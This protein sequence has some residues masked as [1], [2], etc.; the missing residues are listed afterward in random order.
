MNMKA[1]G[2]AKA[3]LER[4]GKTAH[5]I[6]MDEISPQKLLGMKLD[7]LVNCACPRLTDDSGMFRKPVLNPQDVERL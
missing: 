4:K 2:Q 1:A 5:V 7:C 3:M 6:V